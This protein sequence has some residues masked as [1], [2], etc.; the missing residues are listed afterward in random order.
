MNGQESSL[1]TLYFALTVLYL[2]SCLVSHDYLTERWLGNKPA[3]LQKTAQTR[4]HASRECRAC[5]PPSSSPS[6]QSQ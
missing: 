4:W 2:T 6:E 1:T 5:T 3:R